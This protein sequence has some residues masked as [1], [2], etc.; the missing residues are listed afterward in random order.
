MALDTS[1]IVE[2]YKQGQLGQSESLA[3][4][5]NIRFWW[6]LL[7]AKTLAYYTVVKRFYSGGLWG[8]CYKTFY[9]RNLRIFVIS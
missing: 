1:T 3:L 4:F 7:M 2:Y 6:I 8:Q 5:K 9:G